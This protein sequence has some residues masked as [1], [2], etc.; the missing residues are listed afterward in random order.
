MQK[1]WGWELATYLFLG[2]LGGGM[3]TFAAILAIIVAP[4]ILTSALLTWG[5]LVAVLCLLVGT[6]LLV[7]ELGQWPVFERAFVTRTAVIKWGAVLLSVSM[8][9][10]ALFLIW[11]VGW[12]ENWPL[13][14]HVIPSNGFGKFCLGISGITGACVMIYTGVLLSSLKARPFWNTPALPVLFTVSALSTGACL[15]GLCLGHFP[16]P[17][18]WMN[19]EAQ[20][21]IGTAEW[22]LAQEELVH[23]IHI[24]DAI[25]ICAEILT[26]LLFVMLQ[27]CASNVYAK[28]AAERWVRGNMAVVFWVFMFGL[29][30]VVPLIFNLYGGVLGSVVSP[31]MALLAGC[32][33]RFMIL[34]TY[35]R[36]LDEGE[37]R[38]YSRLSQKHEDYMDYWEPGRQ[39]FEIVNADDFDDIPVRVAPEF[40]GAGK[41]FKMAV[42]VKSVKGQRPVEN[43]TFPRIS[44]LPKDMP[45]AEV[46][47]EG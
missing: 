5:V 7:F 31:V 45:Q 40:T 35:D 27:F 12:F 46:P 28:R 36:R 13:L 9:F 42:G 38:Y 11:Q 34:W 43:P 17:T 19:S 20:A 25:L 22:A 37:E 44:V 6:G 8:V 1:F 24:I 33:L 4:G 10:A 47:A 15:L 29:G 30:L 32:L 16:F 41:K 3:L 14:K 2:G 18:S 23:L 21:L 26:I 39:Y